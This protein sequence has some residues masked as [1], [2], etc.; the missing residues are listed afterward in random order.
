MQEKQVPIKYTSRD[1]NSIKNDLV[2]Y[3]KRYYPNSFK[4]FNKASFGAL[5]LDTVA[6]TGDILSFYLDYQANESFLD[7][8][9]EF[10]NVIRHGRELGYKYNP[11]PSSHGYVMIYILVP[12]NANGIGVDSDYFPLLKKGSTFSSDSGD[13]FT[14]VEDIDFSDEKHDIIAAKFDETTSL[15]TYYAIK[16]KGLVI[17]GEY[18]LQLVEIGTHIPF[19]RVEIPTENISEVL[20]IIDSEG[21]IWHEVDELSQ[22]VV[23]LPVRNTNSDKTSVPSILKAYA[24]P[25]RFTVVKEYSRTFLQFGHGSLDQLSAETQAVQDPSKVILSI[26]GKDY[27]TDTSFD[28]SNLLSTDKF[29]VSPVNTTL[30]VRYRKNSIDNVNAAT[31]TI[32]NIQFSN[33][34]FPSVL[35]GAALLSSE[36]SQVLS[37]I[38]VD[39][40][41]PLLGDITVPTVKELKQRIK[42]TFSSQNRA[43]TLTDYKQLAYRMSPQ[44]GAIKKCHVIRDVDSFKRNLNMY[45][46][47]EAS[48]Q[49]LI[50]ANDTL[51]RNLKTWIS[52]HKMIN[53]TID[54]LDAEIVNIGIEFALVSRR[55]SNKFEVLEQ[56]TTALRNKYRD[57]I[58]DIGEPI[59]YTDIYQTLNRVVGVADTT[60][61]KIIQK[62]DSKYSQ[63]S[64][65]VDYF[66]S[67]DGRYLA[68]PQNAIFEI[69]FPLLDI[70]G[71]VK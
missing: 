28:P 58:F 68:I 8:A 14:L 51:K 1:F 5:M 29:G 50:Q 55:K 65:D 41:E 27:I 59:Y 64:Y 42:S 54:I 56:A 12:A 24:V 60:N 34:E 13:L 53:D 26:H 2:N 61:V 6:Y 22:D 47:S 67:P 43:V 48:N 45:I 7:T 23:Y 25:R 71:T 63:I 10:E 32:K 38:E 30:T 21:K 69:K 4:D 11:N 3:A 66:T 19:L 33:M 46:L 70:K 49:T 20:S 31:N 39:N 15:T 57:Y 35:D 62:Y 44:F 52:R 37:S 36:V 9:S 18:G 16:A 17:S 40:D